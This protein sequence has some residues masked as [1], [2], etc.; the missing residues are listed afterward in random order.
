MKEKGY[1]TKEDLFLRNGV[2]ETVVIPS[3]TKFLIQGEYEDRPFYKIDILIY[4]KNVSDIPK[5]LSVD[6]SLKNKMKNISDEI[7]IISDSKYVFNEDPVQNK[8]KEISEIVGKHILDIGIKLEANKNLSS[9]FEEIKKIVDEIKDNLNV[10]SKKDVDLMKLNEEE[11]KAVKFFNQKSKINLK[12]KNNIN[13]YSRYLP[14]IEKAALEW[15][16][17]AVSWSKDKDLKMIDCCLSDFLDVL[18]IG[19]HVNKNKMDLAKEVFNF[20][21]IVR[22][23]FPNDFWEDLIEYEKT[24]KLPS[25]KSKKFKM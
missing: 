12:N 5:I 24:S 3:G 25:Q 20:D 1:L 6:Y 23:S 15:F 13:E 7:A 17:S 16:S 8:L 18:R 4:G 11:S 21:T 14:G 10:L 9:N 22:D 2:N 19:S